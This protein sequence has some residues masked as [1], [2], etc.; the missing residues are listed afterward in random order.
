LYF[1][2]LTKNQASTGKLVYVNMCFLRL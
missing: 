2:V 1:E